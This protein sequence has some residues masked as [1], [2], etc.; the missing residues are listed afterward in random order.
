MERLLV[1]TG[2]YNVE[3][4][5][6]MLSEHGQIGITSMKDGV[7][8]SREIT[9]KEFLEGFETREL[10]PYCEV[11]NAY[12]MITTDGRIALV[13]A[14]AVVH[15]FGMP[16]K[17]EVNN[18]LML[19]EGDNWK[20]QSIAWTVHDLP[21]EKRGFDLNIFAKGYA[22]AWSSQRPEFV[23]MHFEED[24]SLQ[25]NQGA[26]SEGRAAITDVARGFMTDLP[27]MIVTFDSLVTREN[28]VEFHWTLTGTNTGPGGT[29]NRVEVS[30]YES[31][32]L[33][34][35]NRILESKG[36]FSAEEYNRQIMKGTAQ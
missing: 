33:G 12:D 9:F 14:D 5:H 17:R 25:V 22:Q 35:N 29:G 20:L 32:Q 2:N 8:N 3:D 27:D 4:L 23:A 21:E 10:V 24:G 19:K 34:A 28:A 11:V 1:A 31:W 16:G 7:W 18:M 6:T 26:I 36:T 13:R 30:G 15:R